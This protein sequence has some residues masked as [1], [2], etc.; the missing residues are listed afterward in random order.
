MI[1]DDGILLQRFLGRIDEVWLF[2]MPGV[3]SDV[4]RRM[5]LAQV[6][7]Q[8]SLELP[9]LVTDDAAQSHMMSTSS[10]KFALVPRAVF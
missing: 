8:L 9:E 7:D 3:R 1:P 4:R 5:K 2:D 6:Q 10:K